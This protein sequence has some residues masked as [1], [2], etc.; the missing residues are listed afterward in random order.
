[1][2]SDGELARRQ[3][4][5]GD[6]LHAAGMT[7]KDWRHM[8]WMETGHIAHFGLNPDT[9]NWEMETH[10]VGDPEGSFIRSDLGS[11]DSRVPERAMGELRHRDVVKAMGEQMLRAHQ[12]GTPQGPPDGRSSYAYGHYPSRVSHVFT[13]YPEQEGQ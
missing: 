11:D 13:H 8:M 1:M 9:G 2:L 6:A 4:P 12:N 5:V 10:H 7:D 3:P